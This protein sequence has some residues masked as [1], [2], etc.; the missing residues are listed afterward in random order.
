MSVCLFVCC[1]FDILIEVI[2]PHERCTN[3]NDTSET[4]FTS[5]KIEGMCSTSLNLSAFYTGLLPG[6]LF[7]SGEMAE[8]RTKISSALNRLA[9]EIPLDLYHVVSTDIIEHT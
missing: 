5:W 6:H 4:I 1:F 2:V 3:N 9:L 8:G 7:T